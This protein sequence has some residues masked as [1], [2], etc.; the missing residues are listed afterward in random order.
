MASDRFEKLERLYSAIQKVDNSTS[1]EDQ[2]K[3][4]TIMESV[5][6]VPM[7]SYPIDCQDKIIS[8]IREA[9]V[10][11][12]TDE[13]NLLG[14]RIGLHPMSLNDSDPIPTQDTLNDVIESRR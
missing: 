13:I 5:K 1:V 4:E 12:Y 2:N 11:L 10:R 6:D 9:L 7:S 14:D 8:S 3:L